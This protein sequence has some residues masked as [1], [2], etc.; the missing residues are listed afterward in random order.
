MYPGR[1]AGSTNAAEDDAMPSNGAAGQR[2]KPGEGAARDHAG[3][4]DEI[5]AARAMQMVMMSADRLEPGASI[6]KNQ[7]ADGAVGNEL[8]SGTENRGKI[9]RRSVARQIRLKFFERPGVAFTPR[10]Q[11][12]KRR[13]NQRFPSH[14]CYLAWRG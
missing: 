2:F 5:V 7:L 4:G 3:H 11:L 12:Y 14:A 8:L 9:R 6:V 13:R 1:L 10:H